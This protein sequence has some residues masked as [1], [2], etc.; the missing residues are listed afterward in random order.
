MDNKGEA[1]GPDQ[2]TELDTDHR[3]TIRT[4]QGHIVCGSV[5]VIADD[6]SIFWVWLDNGGGRVA[7]HEGDDAK[8]WRARR[9]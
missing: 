4:P 2:W 5:D 8:V 1:L 9:R 3:V 6:A 7:I